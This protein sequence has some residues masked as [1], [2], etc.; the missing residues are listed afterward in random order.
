MKFGVDKV[1]MNPISS[2][3]SPL[4]IRLFDKNNSSIEFEQNNSFVSHF[5]FT[6][7]YIY[8]VCTKFSLVT[9]LI[10]FSYIIKETKMAQ[11]N[12]VKKN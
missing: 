3:E 10:A 4:V 2:I 5:F 7:H 1:Y 8:L 6:D 11:M 9:F 12:V